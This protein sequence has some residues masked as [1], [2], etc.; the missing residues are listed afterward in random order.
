LGEIRN[1]YKFLVEEVGRRGPWGG[2][3]VDFDDN[4]NNDL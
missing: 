4:I 1:E 3:G 2:L